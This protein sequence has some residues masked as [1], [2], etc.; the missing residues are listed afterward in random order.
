MG[1]DVVAVDAQRRVDQLDLSA[2]GDRMVGL[3]RSQH[4][5]DGIDEP[6]Q[7]TLDY[8]RFPAGSDASRQ[9]HEPVGRVAV[10]DSVVVAGRGSGAQPA[11]GGET[12]VEGGGVHRGQQ[13][14]GVDE[15]GQIGRVFD[16]DVRMLALR[17][18]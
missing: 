9:A 11:Q 16:D 12:V 17:P 4:L 2:D 7:E 3:K 10:G 18:L 5:V 8:L 15:V 14:V 1:T 6:G 13:R